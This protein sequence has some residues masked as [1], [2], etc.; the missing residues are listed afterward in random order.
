MIVARC[1]A[2]L[3]D[4][5]DAEAAFDE[6]LPPLRRRPMAARARSLPPRE[7]RALRRSGQRAA[8][9]TELRS[10]LESSNA[11]GAAGF[12]ERARQELRATGETLRAARATSPSS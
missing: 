1:R 10:A 8:A 12:A 5:N 6:A 3:A 7:R 11:L 2:T 4:D 9:R